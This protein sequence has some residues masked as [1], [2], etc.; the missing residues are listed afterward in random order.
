[1]P[2]SAQM[3]RHDACAISAWATASRAVE[4]SSSS[5][6]G[7]HGDEQPGERH[8][9]LLAGR[10]I[11]GGQ[12]RRRAQGRVRRARRSRARPPCPASSSGAEK[13]RDF[14]PT[15]SGAFEGVGM[16]DIMDLLGERLFEAGVSEIVARARAAEVRQARAE[17]SI[18]RRRCGPVTIRLSPLAIAK[19]DDPK[20]RSGRRVRRSDFEAERRMMNRPRARRN[21]AKAAAFV[22]HPC[23][24]SRRNYL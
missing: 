2:P 17:A 18:S 9:P 15:V 16:A 20:K 11:G 22:Y 21:S 4:G 7:R 5:Q 6:I 13:A 23:S 10:E 19:D 8:A 14:R 3:R 12:F 24:S 1:M